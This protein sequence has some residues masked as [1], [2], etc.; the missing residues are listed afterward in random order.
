MK[1]INIEIHRKVLNMSIPMLRCGA[2][3]PC[4]PSTG[5]ILKI[6]NSFYMLLNFSLLIFYL[7]TLCTDLYYNYTDMNVCGNDG[8]YFLGTVMIMFK[9]YKF[10][11]MYDK[12]LKLIDDVYG[13]I[14]TLIRTSD[15]GIIMNIKHSLFFENL[16]F[17]AFLISCLSLSFTI[18]VLTPREKGELPIR[19]VYPFNSTIS[20]YNEMA[21]FYQAY[22][23]LYCLLVIIALDMTTI[24][25]IRWSTIQMKALTANYKNCDAKS[26]K[27]ATLIS[28]SETLKI[29]NEINPW[30]ITDEDLEIR[31]FLPF[32]QSEADDTEDSFVWR[33]RTCIKNHQRLLQLMISVNAT[34]S[35]FLLVQFSTSTLIICMSGFQ[36]ISNTGSHGNLI[37]YTVFLE[38]CFAELLFWCY[39]GDEFNYSADAITY[40]QWMS[41]WENAF[42]KKSIYKMSNLMTIPMNQSIRRLE[43]KAFGMFSLSMPT[44]LSVVKSSYSV[45]VLMTTANSDE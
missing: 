6:L 36:W 25:F 40:S 41:G 14:D 27:R 30:K 43:I 29:I 18:I 45:L 1:Y 12:I 44:F 32:E 42:N 38:I 19:A 2:I 11:T 8:C 16:H 24:A 28:P 31:T 23:V 13:P 22:C 7:I 33:F 35:P 10:R 15:R 26:I 39:Y 9:G 3:W 21:L 5:T 4:V 37:K 20:P 17:Y 34:L